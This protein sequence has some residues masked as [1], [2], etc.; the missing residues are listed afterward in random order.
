MTGS[1][2]ER[3]MLEEHAGAGCFYACLSFGPAGEARY[4]LPMGTK[5][6]GFLVSA[7]IL[8]VGAGVWA[9]NGYQK[10]QH[11]QAVVAAVGETTAR[12]RAALSGNAQDSYKTIDGQLGAVKAAGW[13]PLTDA[14][15]QYIIGAREIARQRAEGARLARAAAA[16]RQA[17]TAHMHA[18]A[19]RTPGWFTQ[20]V[21][22]KKK[23]EQ[24]HRELDRSL[25]ALEELLTTL[26][27]ASKRLEPHVAPAA[28]LEDS[29]RR[30]ARTR[31]QDDARRAA[32]ELTKVRNLTP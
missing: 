31:A 19:R 21:S 17:L 20:A 7:V 29:V 8:A 9:W 1:F 14:A 3:I 12:L 13:S 4:A 25:K 10:K 26:P 24:D 27:E 5:T 11:E 18:G 15:E 6:I 16:G 22:L 2:I 32:A 30:T 28:L 23:V